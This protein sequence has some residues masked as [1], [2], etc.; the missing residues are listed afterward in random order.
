M[1]TVFRVSNPARC[2]LE[3]FDV[4]QLSVWSDYFAVTGPM[5]LTVT[6]WE[7]GAMWHG[8]VNPRPQQW[9]IVQ[10]GRPSLGTTWHNPGLNSSPRHTSNLSNCPK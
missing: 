7:G 5:L 10:T 4:N 1:P 9:P 8:S 6:I 3:G 2:F